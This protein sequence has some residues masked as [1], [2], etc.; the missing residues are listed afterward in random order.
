MR[1]VGLTFFSASVPIKLAVSFVLG[2]WIVMKS[3]IFNS[4]SN[5]TKR[6]FNCAALAGC[7]YGSYATTSM[8]KACMRAATN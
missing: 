2:R 1:T 4:S 5:S 6:T 3:E 8:P 7:R